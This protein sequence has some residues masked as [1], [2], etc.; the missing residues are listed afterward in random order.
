MATA[1][2]Y[3][4]KTFSL[5]FKGE[6]RSMIYACTNLKTLMLQHLHIQSAKTLQPHVVG[7][8]FEPLTQLETLDLSFSKLLRYSYNKILF[9]LY[10]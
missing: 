8:L 1:I 9:S 3:V 2:W 10:K 4:T 6:L 7:K 5:I